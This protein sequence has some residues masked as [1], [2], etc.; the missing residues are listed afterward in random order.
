VED[1]VFFQFVSSSFPGLRSGQAW[2]K[3]L[4]VPGLQRDDVWKEGVEGP[5]TRITAGTYDQIRFRFEEAIEVGETAQLVGFA[6][7]YDEVA[8]L[9]HWLETLRDRQWSPS[10]PQ[11]IRVRV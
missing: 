8:R 11:L 5:T 4:V 2:T 1:G 3:L 10:R 6:T 7:T 9:A